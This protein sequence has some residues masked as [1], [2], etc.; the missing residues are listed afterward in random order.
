M[1][2]LGIVGAA[3][4]SD[5]ETKSTKV[6]KKFAVVVFVDI[7]EGPIVGVS[8]ENQVVYVWIFRCVWREGG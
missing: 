8:I 6:I 3:A 5:I 7:I 4:I 1:C 2:G